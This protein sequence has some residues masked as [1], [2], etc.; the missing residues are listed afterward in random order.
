MLIFL[1]IVTT[2]L[3]LIIGAGL[4]NIFIQRK[5]YSIPLFLTMLLWPLILIIS[6]FSN[7]FAKGE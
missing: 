3:Y 1:S 6:F 4:A 7:N 2:I 5:N